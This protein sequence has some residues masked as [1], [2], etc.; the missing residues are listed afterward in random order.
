MLNKA[1]IRNILA[2]V[3]G[4]AFVRIG[5]YH[6][7]DPEWFE[8]I[9]PEVLG[10]P[11]FWVWLSGIF[12]IGFGILLI[13]PRTREWGSVLGVWMLIA[14]YWANLNMWINDIELGDGT[15]LSAEGHALRLLIQIALILVIAWIGEITP[16]KNEKKGISKM[17]VFQGRISSAAFDTGDRIIVGN[18]HESPLG[19]FSDV[20]WANPEGN[21]TLI[22]PS[23]KVAEYLNSIYSFDETII[24]DI[25][26]I[27]DE[28]Q[29][30]LKCE[31]ME[32]EFKWNKGWKVP[33]KRSLLFIST[34]EGIFAR[35]FF[36]TKTYGLTKNGRKEW[37]AI[38]RVSKLT[39]ATASID[40][41]NLG[42]MNTMKEPCKFGFSE[43]PKKPSSC[44]L[45]THILRN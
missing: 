39:T 13:I 37:Y 14:L 16:F 6:F 25:E 12:E 26:V 28:S 2:L 1:L 3:L 5:I 31:K 24:Q 19:K 18:W 27:G 15:S 38:D 44:V 34:V 33:F 22:A 29:L 35:M 23:D 4:I 42:P 9:V 40:S 7:I 11:R 21:R 32:L 43:A 20:M 30:S 36:G 8:P 10:S 41:T 45:R 17:D